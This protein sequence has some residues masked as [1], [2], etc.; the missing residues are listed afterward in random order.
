MPCTHHFVVVG[1]DFGLAESD[2][3]LTVFANHEF[4]FV[5]VVSLVEELNSRSSTV[6]SE[7]SVRESVAL[8]SVVCGLSV[9]VEVHN[10]SLILLVGSS[11]V[12]SSEVCFLASLLAV[13]FFVVVTCTV[14]SVD[15][16]LVL[17]RSQ[18]DKILIEVD[19]SAVVAHSVLL[20]AVHRACCP[21]FDVLRCLVALCRVEIIVYDEVGNVDNF[22]IVI[23]DR[24]L[25]CYCSEVDFLNLGDGLVV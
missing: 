5:E 12:E 21:T 16:Y 18:S 1:E 2:T 25:H 14:V 4:E 9:F 17:T 13:P 8:H 11:C 10:L 15:C 24:H 7:C 19:G 20:V 6:R 3:C 23:N 22:F